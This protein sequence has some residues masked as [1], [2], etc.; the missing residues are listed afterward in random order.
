MGEADSPFAV[1]LW[2]SKNIISRRLLCH[3]AL[4]ATQTANT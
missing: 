4:S 1:L 3:P 2:Q